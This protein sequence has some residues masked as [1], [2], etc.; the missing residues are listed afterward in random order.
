MPCTPGKCGQAV[1][2]WPQPSAVLPAVCAA[3][4]A[5]TAGPP[6]SLPPAQP[7]SN[8]GQSRCWA[9]QSKAVLLHLKEL[10]TPL[11]FHVSL[12]PS[13]PPCRLAGEWEAA[14]QGSAPTPAAL[15]AGAD[16]LLALSSTASSPPAAGSTVPVQASLAGGN[17]VSH[18]RAAGVS[19][20]AAGTSAAAALS[21]A[22]ALSTHASAVVGPA[23]GPG[24]A[25]CGLDTLWA[26]LMGQDWA[27]SAVSVAAGSRPGLAPEGS[28]QSPFL[29][30]LQVAQ[31][32][33]ARPAGPWARRPRRLTVRPEARARL[34]RLQAYLAAECEALGPGSLQQEL[35]LLQRLLAS[36]C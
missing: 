23:A 34:Q 22:R 28:R 9:A 11:I 19:L 3:V 36:A 14:G 13:V 25:A 21:V 12:P 35:A 8:T 31:Q 4:A 17:G 2:A 5:C 7:F 33:A 24:G 10:R 26:R 18:S 30:T 16:A 6:S 27:A 20:A 29:S 32:P 1:A 15:P